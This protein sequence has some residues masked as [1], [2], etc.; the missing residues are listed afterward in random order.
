MFG[1][2]NDIL[3]RRF[4]VKFMSV[5]VRYAFAYFYDGILSGNGA[6]DGLCCVFCLFRFL[7]A[8]ILK[9]CPGV[10]DVR[11]DDRDCFL[12]RVLLLF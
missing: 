10:N 1:H 7:I 6:S 11:L 8:F 3:Y 4:V 12:V 2:V 5:S 9:F